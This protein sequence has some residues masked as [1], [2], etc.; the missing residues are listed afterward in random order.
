MSTFLKAPCLSCNVWISWIPLLVKKSVTK[1]EH[2]PV[3]ALPAVGRLWPRLTKFLFRLLAQGLCPPGTF[4]MQFLSSLRY[5]PCVM[6]KSK[7]D[8]LSSSF[9][10]K[11]PG[12][13]ILAFLVSNSAQISIFG[14]KYLRDPPH[15]TLHHKAQGAPSPTTGSPLW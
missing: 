1:N 9:G 6:K 4:N 13:N 12:V 7:K 14:L 11:W 15:L 3:Q 2:D 10:L 5:F 8:M